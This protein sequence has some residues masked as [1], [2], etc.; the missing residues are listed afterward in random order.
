[1]RIEKFSHPGAR[2]IIEGTLEYYGFKC[3][4]YANGYYSWWKN[5]GKNDTPDESKWAKVWIYPAQKERVWSIYA[6]YNSWEHNKICIKDKDCFDT[7]E[8]A[9]L[10]EE[11][12]WITEEL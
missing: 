8:F 11:N 3:R 4:G 10:M 2:K 5:N 6:G 12:K 7:E 1:M 9:S